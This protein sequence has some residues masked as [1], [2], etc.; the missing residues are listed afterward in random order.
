MLNAYE[1]V[2]IQKFK[3]ELE[4]NGEV[5]FL[6]KDLYET[7]GD[8]DF[9][10][11]LSSY[12]SKIIREFEYINTRIDS[13]YIHAE[14]SRKI[15]ELI[16]SIRKFLENIGSIKIFIRSEYADVLEELKNFMKPSGGTVIPDEF[17]EIKIIETEPIFISDNTI[18]KKIGKTL[19]LHPVGKGSYADVYMFEDEDYEECFT[20]KRLNKKATDKDF[21][22]LKREYE[23]MKGLDSPFIVKV[24]KMNYDKKEYTMEYLNDTLYNHIQKK[25]SL[26]NIESR[27]YIINQI[28]KGFEYLDKKGILHRDISPTN[29]LL[30]HY[31]DE[32]MLIKISDF[33]LVKLEESTL[34]DPNSEFRGSLND[35]RLRDIGFDQYNVTYEMYALTR[36][37]A[38]ILTGKSAFAKITDSDTLAFLNKGISDKQE[39]RYQNIYELGLEVRKLIGK[40]KSKE[41]R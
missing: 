20:L 12:H 24:Y 29:I 31:E 32:T 30:K 37:I 36:L 16:G 26:L 19:R 39:E 2:L 33:G 27:S 5:D 38:Y 13:R 34:T 7:F 21:E 28:L 35:Y 1:K 40:L 9:I 15:I 41:A 17:K 18:S 10:V 3:R 25:N 22:R 4:S 8:D 11:F 23:T 14:N 6:Y